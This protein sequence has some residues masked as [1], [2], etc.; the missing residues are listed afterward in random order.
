MAIGKRKRNKRKNKHSLQKLLF[1]FLVSFVLLLIF[2][3][4]QDWTKLNKSKT[5]RT[6]F[7]QANNL[8]ILTPT[9][10][11][12][13][14]PIKKF[15][16]TPTQIPVYLPNDKCPNLFNYFENDYFSI[17]YPSDMSLAR[18]DSFEAIF[19]NDNFGLYVS[20]AGGGSSGL[21]Q[22]YENM[23]INVDGQKLETRVYKQPISEDNN[24]LIDCGRVVQLQNFFGDID[25]TVIYTSRDWD[26]DFETI[27]ESTKSG[28]Q[29]IDYKKYLII[30]NSFKIKKQSPFYDAYHQGSNE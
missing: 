28:R 5:Q 17:C 13:T 16:P 21:H 30:I 15:T 14:V 10:Y 25:Y 1:I 18:S 9:L 6:T 7:S 23:T 24:T 22:C 8:S 19:R 27:S 26:S 4:I 29:S 20:P 11:P 2:T 3:I 12:P